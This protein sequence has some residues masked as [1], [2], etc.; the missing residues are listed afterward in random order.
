MFKKKK[1]LKLKK[2]VNKNYKKKCKKKKSC[3]NHSGW[4]KG[5]KAHFLHWAMTPSSHPFQSKTPRSIHFCVLA[6][7]MIYNHEQRSKYGPRSAALASPRNVLEMQIL[8]SLRV[9]SSQLYSNKPYR[10]LRC[11][12]KSE[13]HCRTTLPPTCYPKHRFSALCVLLTTIA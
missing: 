6:Q 7:C 11:T 10:W 8:G 3:P 2:W 12:V 1:K 5:G 9:G 4:G 13:N